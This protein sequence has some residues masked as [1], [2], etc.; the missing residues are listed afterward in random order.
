MRR[1]TCLVL[2]VLL[3]GGLL[4][5]AGLA[6]APKKPESDR[7]SGDAASTR[8]S[9]KPSPKNSARPPAPQVSAERAADALKFAKQHHPELARLLEGLKKA[10]RPN[11]ERGL[12]SLIR[13][14]E[15]LTKMAERDDERYSVSLNL[16]ELESRI[17]L[18]TARLSVSPMEDFDARLRPLLEQRRDAR[19]RM[20][21]LERGRLLE[22][23][24]KYNEQ[25][26]KLKASADEEV[27]AEIAQLQKL[28][29]VRKRQGTRRPESSGKSKENPTTDPRRKSSTASSKSTS[30]SGKTVVRRK[31]TNTA[32]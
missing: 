11:Y 29:S 7:T 26:E 3:S 1:A 25:L 21:E 28:A 14:S 6:D 9:R 18:E 4:A 31:P 27:V 13:D 30:Q 19:I 10:D 12:A 32:D 2:A 20:V 24:E 22:R 16:W 23:L 17:R 15:R 5:A 8:N